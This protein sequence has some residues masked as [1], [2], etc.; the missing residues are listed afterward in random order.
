[1]TLLTYLLTKL[2]HY[3]TLF[4]NS[5]LAEDVDMTQYYRGKLDALHDMLNFMLADA[6]EDKHD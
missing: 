5:L 1:M 3:Q 6:Q 4:D 2:H